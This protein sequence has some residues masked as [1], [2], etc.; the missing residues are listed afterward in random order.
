MSYQPTAKRV[1]SGHL[2]MKDEFFGILVYAW[3]TL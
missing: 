2:R 3:M 1:T